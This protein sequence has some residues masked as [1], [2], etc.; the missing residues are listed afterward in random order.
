MSKYAPL[1]DYLMRQRHREFDMTF[2]EVEA[3]IGAPLP[4]SAARPQWWANVNDQATTH[5][6]REAW[7][8]A[9]YDVFLISGSDKVRFR[10]VV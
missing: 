2:R 3:V 7:R 1:R 5:V 9:G 10:K 8:S 6:Q 4:S